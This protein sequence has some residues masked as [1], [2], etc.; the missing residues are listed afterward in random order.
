MKPKLQSSKCI[1]LDVCGRPLFANPATII[2]NQWSMHAHTFY[3]KR[4]STLLIRTTTIPLICSGCFLWVVSWRCLPCS[5]WEHS[6]VIICH[7]QWAIDT[8]S[9]KFLPRCFYI[10]FLHFQWYWESTVK[11]WDA[12][13]PHI[14]IACQPTL[15]SPMITCLCYRYQ[16]G[17]RIF[18]KGGANS[19][20]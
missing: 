14:P 11:T 20:Y 7:K 6:G 2:D 12:F 15:P 10:H 18:G 16:G 19:R 9:L 1:E 4:T 5:Y 13:S 17:S 3:H 8:E